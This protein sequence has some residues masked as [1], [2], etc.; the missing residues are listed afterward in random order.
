MNGSRGEGHGEVP[1]PYSMDP[2]AEARASV[3]ARL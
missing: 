2:E 1:A 3:S